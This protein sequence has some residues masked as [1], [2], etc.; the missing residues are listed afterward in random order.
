MKIENLNNETTPGKY[1]NCFVSDHV[2]NHPKN[3]PSSKSAA[4]TAT[5]SPAMQHM[6]IN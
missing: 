2:G 5:I 3:R 1:G 6:K 4:R